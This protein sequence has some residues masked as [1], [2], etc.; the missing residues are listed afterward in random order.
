[1]YFVTDSVIYTVF[2]SLDTDNL[3][4]LLKSYFPCSKLLEYTA[5]GMQ[6]MAGF[7][8]LPGNSDNR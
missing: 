8:E 7:A 6:E 4:L 3:I 1:M 2:I 5:D